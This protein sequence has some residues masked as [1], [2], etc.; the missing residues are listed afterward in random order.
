M[1]PATMWAL[2]GRAPPFMAPPCVAPPAKTHPH[3]SCDIPFRD[4]QRSETIRDFSDYQ[5][6]QIG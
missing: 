1:R 3:G 2:P 4:Y 6:L 5:R